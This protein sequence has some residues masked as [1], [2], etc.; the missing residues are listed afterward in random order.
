LLVERF[1]GTEHEQ[2]VFQAQASQLSMEIA[3]QA[4]GEE[5]RQILLAL[6]IKRVNQE[7]NLLNQKAAVNPALR[8]E[9]SRRLHELRLLKE[10]RS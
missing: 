6:R 1:Q 9:L 10:Q 2:V 7:I 8:P 3:E 5:F 4:A